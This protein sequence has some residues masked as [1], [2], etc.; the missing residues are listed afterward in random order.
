MTLRYYTRKL[1]TSDSSFSPKRKRLISSSI[2]LYLHW[3]YQSRCLWLCCAI[4]FILPLIQLVNITLLHLYKMRWEG[5]EIERGGYMP[6]LLN[7]GANKHKK[8]LVWSRNSDIA[9]TLNFKS[10]DNLQYIGDFYFIQ[11]SSGRC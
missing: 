11:N 4:F 2:L 5:S 3:L 9:M 7:L 10:N 8:L 6:I 1:C